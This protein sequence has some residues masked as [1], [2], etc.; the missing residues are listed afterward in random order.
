MKPL[1]ILI[2]VLIC[3]DQPWPPSIRAEFQQRAN[4]AWQYADTN[5]A[6][7]W[8]IGQIRWEVERLEREFRGT[9]NLKVLEEQADRVIAST[10]MWIHFRRRTD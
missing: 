1:L 7:P 6:Q 9:N 8:D 4:A 3:A 5:R 10:V 2:S